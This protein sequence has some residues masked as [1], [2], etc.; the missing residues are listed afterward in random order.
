MYV[1]SMYWCIILK[2]W[3]AS[4]ASCAFHH[5]HSFV[6]L[7]ASDSYESLYIVWLC[8]V[9]LRLIKGVVQ[10]FGGSLFQ[11]ILPRL[12]RECLFQIFPNYCVQKADLRKKIFGQVGEIVAYDALIN[13]VDRIPL[14]W[15]N[16]GLGNPGSWASESAGH[17]YFDLF[18]VRSL[19]RITNAGS[20]D[21][22]S[23]FW[24]NAKWVVTVVLR[25]MSRQIKTWNTFII[26]VVVKDRGAT[27]LSA[28]PHGFLS[29]KEM[30][31]QILPK[32]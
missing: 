30:H 1:Y 18:C 5:V 11:H 17:L 29:W 13:N 21:K 4:S 28:C 25:D 27:K 12:C 15:D 16:E 19:F 10:E 23:P 8:Y 26:L 20:S 6:I 31:E 32:E 7:K 9:W 2:C 22:I 3:V 24:T 14:L